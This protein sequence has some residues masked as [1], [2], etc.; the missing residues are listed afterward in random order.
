MS[1]VTEVMGSME[2]GDNEGDSDVLPVLKSVSL[3]L[4]F[5]LITRPVLQADKR[6]SHP[7]L[8]AR[9]AGPTPRLCPTQRP[10]TTTSC[11]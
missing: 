10:G 2:K 6:H 3:R 5:D 11:D 8:S 1:G 4:P 7:S 9:Q